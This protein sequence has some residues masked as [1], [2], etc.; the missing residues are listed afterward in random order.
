[1]VLFNRFLKLLEV[2]VKRYA[3]AA[4]TLF[5]KLR[6]VAG[7]G[8]DTCPAQARLSCPRAKLWWA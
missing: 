8:P 1:M 3:F 7:Q 4:V 5:S 2:L 6:V